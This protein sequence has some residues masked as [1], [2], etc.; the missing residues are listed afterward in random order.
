MSETGNGLPDL[1]S[2]YPLTDDQ[3]AAFRRNGHVHLA[4]VC[5]AEEVA[6]Y[7]PIIAATAHARFAPKAPLAERDTAGMAFLQTLNLRQHSEGVKQF[8]LAPRFARIVADLLGVDALRIYHEQVLFKEP[9]GG[10]TPWHQD[11]YYWPLAT[12]NTMGL[13]MPLQDTPLEMGPIQFASGSHRDGFL[14]QHI[15]SDES[16]TVFDNF[17]REK[18]YPLWQRSM[19]AGDATFHYG[20]TVHGATANR[21]DRM[22]EAMIVTYYED[23]TRVDE[24]SNPSRVG[25][26]E[27]FLGGRHTGEVAD[28]DLNTVV[29]RR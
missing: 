3:V 6:A 9:G 22:R 12:D 29:Y 15:I 20:W 4:G 21:T 16:E 25:D 28:S 10:I 14:G 11:Q 7:E 18:D 5:S 1:A 2:P 13:W 27:H 17:I 24:L 26:A 23:G 19:R 8:V